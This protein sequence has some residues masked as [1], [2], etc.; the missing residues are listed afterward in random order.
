[1][2]NFCKIKDALE[3]IENHLD[4][5]MSFKKLAQKFNFSPYYFHRM[6]SIIVGKTISAYIRDRRLQL[7]CIALTTTNN[8]VTNIG[9]DCGYDSAQSFSRTFKQI[10]GISPSE[11]RKQGLIPLVL[12]VDEM[13][14]NFTNKLKGGIY[15]N[16]KIKQKDSLIIAG[17]S[18]DVRYIGT[19]EIWQNFESLSNKTPLVNK[20]CETGY[21]VRTNVVTDGEEIE[22]VYTGN[23]VSNE[24][25]DAGYVLIKLPASK[26]IVFDVIIKAPDIEGGERDFM[27]DWLKS[28]Q[29]YKERL[30]DGTRYLIA[31]YDERYTGAVDGAII[32]Y[33]IPV[34]MK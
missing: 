11:Y 16:P 30:F 22:I 19:P 20:I 7:A 18:G 25:V 10:Y 12:S 9:L 14:L 13:I 21:E 2:N 6:F 1:L 24:N 31:S 3:Y 23:A 33:W 4:E 27:Y 5:P 15:M 17:T 26:Y 29:E 28:H 32:E 34:E 8:P